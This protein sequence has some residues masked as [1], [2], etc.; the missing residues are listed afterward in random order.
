MLKKTVGALLAMLCAGGLLAGVAS[1]K[2]EVLLQEMV[3]L[4]KTYIPPLFFTNQPDKVQAANK[5]MKLLRAEWNGFKQAYYDY[6]P[7]YANW[8]RYFDDIEFAIQDAE[9]VV[10]SV[11]AENPQ[12]LVL[13]HEAL[14][15]V[16]ATMLSLRPQ[17]GFPKFITDKLTIYHDPMEHIVISLK[18]QPMSA[19]LIEEVKAT[20]VVAEKAWSDVEKCPVDPGMWG[21][22]TDKMQ[23]YYD[24]V[25]RE[26]AALDRLAEALESGDPMA[27]K[28]AGTLALKQPFVETY[29]LFGDMAPF[30]PP[31]P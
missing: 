6:K 24:L 23:Q 9:A 8:Q 26:R 12:T 3:N 7:D 18:T 14:E 10:A 31:A 25:V 1:A 17:N 30:T 27:I 11:T 21:F 2:D 29:I 16:R 20:Y 13:A 28:M 19:A 15:G 5:A 22:S 4:E